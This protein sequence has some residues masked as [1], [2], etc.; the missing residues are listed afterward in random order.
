MQISAEA[1]RIVAA[2][3]A[4]REFSGEGLMDCRAALRSANGDP[5]LGLGL[6]RAKGL[7]V[8]VKGDRLAWNLRQAESYAKL[9][10]LDDQGVIRH[11]EPGLE[12]SPC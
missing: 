5:L 12:M 6:M 4:M 11:A 9:L 10:I 2:V 7:C 3:K 1:K 8:N